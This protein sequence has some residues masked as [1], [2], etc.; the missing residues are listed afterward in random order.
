MN[1]SIK[2]Q[3]NIAGNIVLIRAHGHAHI[4]YLD[5]VSFEC[6][7]CSPTCWIVRPVTDV[8]KKMAS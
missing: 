2:F 3:Q 5:M 7:K 8:Y 1:K 6:W 4:T